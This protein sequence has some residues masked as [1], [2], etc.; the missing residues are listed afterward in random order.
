MAK[1]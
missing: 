1:T